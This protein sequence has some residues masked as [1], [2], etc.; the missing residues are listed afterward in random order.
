MFMPSIP[1]VEAIFKR[2][3]YAFF[4]KGDYNVNIIGIRHSRSVTNKFDDTLLLAYRESG[5]WCAEYIPCTTDPGL[6]PMKNP[7]PKGRAVLVPGQYRGCFKLGKHKGRETALVQFK[8]VKV[9]RDKNRDDY[10]DYVNPEFGMFGINIHWSSQTQTS[11]Q[12]DNWSEGC[13]VG[14]GP[15][16][17]ETFLRIIKKAAALWGDVFTYTLVERQDFTGGRE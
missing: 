2:K 1:E 8:P 7:L 4:T 14:T 15:R 16:N 5:A 9:Y 12:V 13:T 17:R 11:V 3:G 6:G 10:M